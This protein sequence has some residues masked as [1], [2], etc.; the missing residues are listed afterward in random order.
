MNQFDQSVKDIL[1]QRLLTLEQTFNSDVIFFYGI[2]SPGIIKIFR[3][4]IEKLKSDDTKREHIT[5]FLNTPGGSVETVEKLV[6]II[7]HHYQFVYFV[8]PDFA[9]SAG[10]I[11]CMAGDNIYMDY[12]S[13]LGP[14][15]PKIFNGKEWVPAQGYLDQYQKL[16]DKANNNQLTN[17]EF[18]ILQS[19]DLAKLNVCEQ[20][21][22]LT[23]TLLKKWL[24]EYKFKNWLKHKDGR[25]VTPDEKTKKAEEV[26]RILGDNK[27]WHTHSRM[28]GLDDIDKTLKLRIENYSKDIPL[29]KKIREYNDLMTEFIA[30]RGYTLFL[31]SRNYF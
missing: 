28:I 21:K 2:I 25:P 24:V 22:E 27:L 30:R 26:A 20:A 19:Q 18:L 1:D 4:F 7:R 11:F 15:D 12:S 16:I 3:D 13:S 29:Q 23:I 31:H 17:A 10:T 9:M 8:V 14:I 6:N 5:I